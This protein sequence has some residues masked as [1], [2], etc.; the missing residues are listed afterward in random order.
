MN[1]QPSSPKLRLA[2][3]TSTLMSLST[4]SS[5]QTE[6]PGNNTLGNPGNSSVTTIQGAETV[7]RTV[8]TSIYSL[9]TSTYSLTVNGNLTTTGNQTIRG[10]LQVQ[11]GIKLTQSQITHLGSGTEAHHAVNKSQ[12][13]NTYREANLYTDQAVRAGTQQSQQAAI[14]QANSYTDTQIGLV[15]QDLN[16]VG[17]VAV[18][19]SVVGGVALEP[20][21]QGAVTVAMGSYRDATAIALGVTYRVAPTVRLFGT[22]SHTNSGSAKQQGST[23]YGTGLSWSF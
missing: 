5:A 8:K 10:G 6:L 23:G 20:G 16:A 17:A 14:N 2:L 9:N 21:Q 22:V 12:L 11:N 13:D 18:A 3:L 19:T 1:T 15:R 4:I 7:I